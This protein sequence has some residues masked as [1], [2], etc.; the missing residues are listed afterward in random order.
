M[1]LKK[2]IAVSTKSEI[3]EL[4]ANRSN[5]LVLE[6]KATGKKQFFS[7]RRFQFTPLES[8]S[9]YTQDD[10]VELSEVFKT[11][12][13]QMETNPPVATKA[14]NEEIKKYFESILPTFDRDR[15]Y[16]SDI[17][18]LIKWFTFLKNYDLLNRPEEVEET[19]E[20]VE[21]ETAE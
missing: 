8:I 9:I 11:M 19:E 1:N 15:V 17:K 5:G 6:D 4:V 20:A 3:F 10:T 14:S 7:S 2:L 18:K 12:L 13:E 16:T 21:E